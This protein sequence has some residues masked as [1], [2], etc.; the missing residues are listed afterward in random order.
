MADTPEPSRFDLARFSEA[1]RRRLYDRTAE[2]AFA[3]R[4]HTPDEAGLQIVYIA[5]R[6]FA[7]W[8]DLDEP[9]SLPDHLRVRLVRI[10]E[11]PD[12]PD[13]ALYDL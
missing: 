8:T 6:W 2:I 4:G 7:A 1:V 11:D 3:E 9:P 5:G 13:I 10:E 12:R